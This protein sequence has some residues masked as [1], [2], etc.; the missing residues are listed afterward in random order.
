MSSMQ[1]NSNDADIIALSE[2]VQAVALESVQADVEG[3]PSNSRTSGNQPNDRILEL[4]TMLYNLLTLVR[5][6]EKFG[7]DREHDRECKNFYFHQLHQSVSELLLTK[8]HYVAFY[9][10]YESLVIASFDPED[11]DNFKESWHVVI[12]DS[13]AI[14]L[15]V[16]G[17]LTD[18]YPLPNPQTQ[19]EWSDSINFIIRKTNF[20]GSRLS[21]S[22][23]RSN[24]GASNN[25]IYGIC[26]K[27]CRDEE[28]MKKK[29]EKSFLIRYVGKTE[30]SARERGGQYSP[31]SMNKH[32]C[33][34][35]ASFPKVMEMI[36]LPISD[37][38]KIN[39]LNS[40]ECFWQ[41]FFRCRAFRGGWSILANDQLQILIDRKKKN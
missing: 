18:Q 23:Q 30:Q 10:R 16:G 32:T 39:S 28:K 33:A 4:R 7:M 36:L 31:S 15:D 1:K 26:C 38:N 41:F 27:L 22:E 40:W 37:Q 25:V 21:F 8:D 9:G 6:S 19:F 20:E 13:V 35:K 11:L 24:W 14:Y 29:K 3:S 2:G 34:H 12:E 17:Q 5:T